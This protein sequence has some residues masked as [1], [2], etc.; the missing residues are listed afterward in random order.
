ML[1]VREPDLLHYLVR[2]SRTWG[3]AIRRLVRFVPLL[4]GA[5]HFSLQLG[6]RQF[7]VRHD[8]PSGAEDSELAWGLILLRG[9]Q[10]SGVHIRPTAVRLKQRHAPMNHYE[11]LFDAPITFGAPVNEAVF[12]RVL[13]EL[14]F[15]TA[16]PRLC[17]V[18]E[19]VAETLLR[20]GDAGSREVA[21]P[22][23]HRCA[24]RDAGFTREVRVA[25]AHCLDNGNPNID[26]VAEHLGI[27]TRSLQRHL[28]R[29]KTSHRE[30]LEE[31]RHALL[32]RFSGST[33]LSRARMAKLLAY[34]S[35]RSVVRRQHGERPLAPSVA[36]P[37]ASPGQQPGDAGRSTWD[38]PA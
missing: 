4:V 30:L 12:D 1:E 15:T 33:E 22:S 35:T 26:R 34:E 28:Q 17:V 25:V 19:A 23:G 32:E 6:E 21:R 24:A 20:R 36:G 16:E 10:F 9:R 7:H 38:Q 37:P 18:L 31:A 11:Q 5:G 2:S 13:F 8:P 27:S 3:D 29:E 14:P